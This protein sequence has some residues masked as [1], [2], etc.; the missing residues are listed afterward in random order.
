V[1]AGPRL[2]SYYERYLHTF[3]LAR[4]QGAGVPGQDI[5]FSIGGAAAALVPGA[6]RILPHAVAIAA[7]LGPAI[8]VGYRRRSPRAATWTFGLFL[9][10][11]PLL[12]PMSE[13]HHLAL[14]FPAAAWTTLALVYRS[15]EAGRG[16]D[17]M[18]A[19]L[20]AAGWVFFWLGRLDRPGPYYLISLVA[21]YLAT[22]REAWR[23]A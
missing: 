6:P 14:L 15:D 7:V 9:I 13:V 10:A 21:F 18:G 17:A 19:T 23:D 11:I 2:W 16:G 1:C 3:V 5:L 20:T 22:L 4:T 12:T 8:W